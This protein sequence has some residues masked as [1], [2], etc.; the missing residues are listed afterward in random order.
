MFFSSIYNPILAP[1]KATKFRVWDDYYAIVDWVVNEHKIKGVA[2]MGIVHRQDA[3]WTGVH[4]WT[5]GSKV[6]RE[7]SD[8]KEVQS[9]LVQ[10][11]HEGEFYSGFSQ[12]ETTNKTKFYRI[13]EEYIVTNCPPLIEVL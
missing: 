8:L 2:K 7:V 6:F 4:G 5:N 10:G 1:I 3:G 13:N 9:F 12:T 11:E